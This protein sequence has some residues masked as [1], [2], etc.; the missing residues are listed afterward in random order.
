MFDIIQWIITV[1]SASLIAS[2]TQLLFLKPNKRIK[3]AEAKS[4]EFELLKKQIE[5]AHERIDKLQQDLGKSEEE[6]RQSRRELEASEVKRYKLKSC[7]S[8]A[9]ECPHAK[10]CLVLWRQREL[11]NECIKENKENN[12]ENK[13]NDGNNSKN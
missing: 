5:N 13:N 12:N 3:E 2:I 1:G 10:S 7:I 4:I 6:K 11:E 9:Y 8:R